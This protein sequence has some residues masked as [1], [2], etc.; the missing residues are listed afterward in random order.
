M[1]D[2]AVSG[3]LH[4]TDAQVV[5]VGLGDVVHTGEASGQLSWVDDTAMLPANEDGCEMTLEQA[6][7]DTLEVKDN[8]RC[9]GLNVTFDGVYRRVP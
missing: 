1:L 7:P 2:A 6:G 4:L 5:W 3:D 9:G 8:M